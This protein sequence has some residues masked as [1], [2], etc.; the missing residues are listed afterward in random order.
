MVDLSGLIELMETLRER[1]KRFG[2]DLE[3]NEALTRYALV[4]PV[5]RAMGWATDD[6]GQVRVEFPAGTTGGAKAD[7]CLLD[8]DGKPRMLLEV[9]SLHSPKVPLA[10]TAV[11][12]YAFHLLNSGVSGPLSVGITDGLKWEFYD[13]PD[14]KQPKFAV[15]L[16][17]GTPAQAAVRLLEALWRPLILGVAGAKGLTAPAPVIPPPTPAA[18][19]EPA[20]VQSLDRL[21]VK[22][23]D[24]P[25]RRLLLPDGTSRKLGAWKD[26]LVEV[27]NYL[28]EANK[29]TPAMCP[30]KPDGAYS[31][32]LVHVD[33]RHP[34]G[35]EFREPKQLKNGLWVETN[36]KASD[37]LRYSRFLLTRCGED[38]GAYRVDFGS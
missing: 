25:P 2:P 5:L 3:K 29:L 4:D 27:A 12:G 13:I 16:A 21:E 8:S 33:G 15:N 23:G 18:R 32:Y 26:L 36:L 20:K 1:V 9:K 28:V 31:R 19:A 17:E 34:S 38:P 6:P 35:V 10:T 14:L 24:V 37:I 22:S 11:V 30:I 7:Y